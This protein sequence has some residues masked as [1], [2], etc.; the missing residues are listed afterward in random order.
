MICFEVMASNPT[1]I[2]LY[3]HLSD[4]AEQAKEHPSRIE[5]LIYRHVI[6]PDAEIRHGRSMQPI[7]F[8]S[9]VVEII[10][11]IRKLRE[12]MEKALA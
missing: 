8:Q 10:K 7:F 6:Q 11:A 9:R 2:P 3:V 12:A 5:K 1:S 4:L